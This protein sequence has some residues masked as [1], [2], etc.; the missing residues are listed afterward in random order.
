MGK[1]KKVFYFI[2]KGRFLYLFSKLGSFTKLFISSNITLLPPTSLMIEPT[3]ICNLKCPL[4]PTGLGV[5]N[6]VKRSMSVDEYKT[7][8]D[9]VK[10]YVK[11]IVL[12]HYGEPFVHK[13]ILAMIEYATKKKIAIIT[14]TNGHFLNSLEYC[15]KV[16]K[17]GLQ[18]MIVAIDGADQEAYEKFRAGG[19]LNKV[20]RGVKWLVEA[21]KNLKSKTPYIEMQF[22]VMKHNEH[23][24]QQM[25]DLAKDLK[26]D[27]FIE[28][29]VGIHADDATF[30]NMRDQFLPKE[31]DGRFY[32][33]ENGLSQVNGT[34]PNYCEWPYRYAVI[35]SDGNVVP[36]SLDIHSAHIMGN[37]FNKDLL[38][39]WRSNEYQNFRK[40]IRSNR[41]NIDMCRACPN[42]VCFNEN[43]TSLS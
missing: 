20:I 25:K 31:Q 23:Q 11:E 43:P 17:S 30:F 14:S 26:V 35:N 6:R 40:Q 37:V 28:K 36:C 33:D 10:G 18:R 32:K 27:Y 7:I 16:V 2:Q 42:G 4:C 29:E 22:I 34:V 5:L 39:I 3:N 19:N 21:K 12:W 38:A 15:E 8:I 9:Q 13:N 24:K 41:K 1:L